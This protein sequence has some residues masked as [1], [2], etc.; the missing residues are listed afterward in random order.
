M[1][2]YHSA[3]AYAR[4]RELGFELPGL[5]SLRVDPHGFQGK[6][7][8]HYSPSGNWMSFGTVGSMTPKMQT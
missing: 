2:Y 1:A 7:N 6:D 4:L 3:L 8:S 5:A